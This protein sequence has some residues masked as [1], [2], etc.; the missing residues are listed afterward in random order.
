MLSAPT[1]ALISVNTLA[2]QLQAQPEAVIAFCQTRGI[3]TA[4]LYNGGEHMMDFSAVNENFIRDFA[5]TNLSQTLE[6]I[7]QQGM[8]AIASLR[9]G[10]PAPMTTTTEP[11]Q[12]E[13]PTETTE[14]PK[15]QAKGKAWK[16]GKKGNTVRETVIN[17]INQNDPGGDKGFLESLRAQDERAIALQTKVVEKL[18]NNSARSKTTLSK[19]I[20]NYLAELDNAGVSTTATP[21]AEAPAQTKKT[22]PRQPKKQPAAQA[23]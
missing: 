21:A 1:P 2:S 17:L 23:S 5:V 7:V 18:Y 10:M 16:L 12:T 6:P 8:Q 11:T 14:V 20:A 13:S 4:P 19:E 9:D 3:F 15:K 22:R